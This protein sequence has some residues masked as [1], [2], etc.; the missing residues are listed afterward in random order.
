MSDE[1]RPGRPQGDE[2]ATAEEEAAAAALRRALEDGEAAGP[3]RAEAE[4]AALLDFS[5]DAGAL[6]AERAAAVLRRVLGPEPERAAS[7]RRPRRL[8]WRWLVPAAATCAAA[9]AVLL[10][11]SL[12]APGPGLPAPPRALLQAQVAASRG[13]PGAGSAVEK[14]MGAYRERIYATLGKRYTRGR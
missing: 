13:G 12:R 11:L 14:E 6:P 4:A 7:P 1:R 3:A 2:P 8:L 10:A 9:A 5:R